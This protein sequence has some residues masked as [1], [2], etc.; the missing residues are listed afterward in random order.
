MTCSNWKM[1]GYTDLTIS[2]TLTSMFFFSNKRWVKTE[3]YIL[4]LFFWIAARSEISQEDMLYY[5]FLLVAITIFDICE[6]FLVK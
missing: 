6:G 1:S 4:A 5:N 3:T 2:K